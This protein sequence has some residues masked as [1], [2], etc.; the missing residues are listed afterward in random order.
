SRPDGYV[1]DPCRALPER[2]EHGTIAELRDGDPV[3]R[4]CRD[5]NERR[6]DTDHPEA[7]SPTLR[8]QTL[9]DGARSER[10]Q[11]ETADG[12]EEIELP[13]VPNHP[14]KREPPV[15]R[16]V[17]RE[18]GKRRAQDQHESR[19][20]DRPVE[21]PEQPV[22]PPPPTREAQEHEPCEDRPA[23]CRRPKKPSRPRGE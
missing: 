23:I 19:R 6:E 13:R 5:E 11:D 15:Q 2:L 12:G 4:R 8:R 14:E 18:G 10:H 17:E 1:E 16:L 22:S 20:Q 9:Q 7:S 21:K 3:P